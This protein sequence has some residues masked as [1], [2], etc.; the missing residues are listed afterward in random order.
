V[1]NAARKI[2][3]R[4][5]AIIPVHLGGQPCDMAEIHDL[6]AT[7]QLHVIEDAAHALP[8]EY[9]GKR[10]GAVSEITAFSFYATKTLTTGEGGMVTTGNES[11]TKRMRLMRLHGITR[12]TAN[13]SDG[14]N[15]WRYQV[16]EA[17][18]KYNFTDIQAAMG[19]IQLAKCD[20]MCAARQR[21]AG[22]YSRKLA[23]LEAFD[24]PPILPDRRTSWHLYVLRLKPSCLRIDR[25]RFIMELAERGVGTSVHFIP[26]HLQPFYQR[27]FGYKPGDFPVA[28]QEYE[29][30]FSLPIFPSMTEE[31]IEHVVT[32]VSE[33][34]KHWANN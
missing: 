25:D 1:Q 13:G 32:A 8:S 18:Y 11:Y 31:E 24:L 16:H 33:V 12:E 6:A 30:S 2:T 21:I 5:R 10:I 7:H 34:V 19:I 28:E 27:S 15:S 23:N 26:L 14:Q 4:T 17:G 3:S 29:R 20:E 22:I 9:R